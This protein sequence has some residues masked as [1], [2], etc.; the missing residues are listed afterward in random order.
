MELL[1][2]SD[3]RGIH[4]T[5]AW[6][7]AVESNRPGIQ[8][9]NF[10]VAIDP[11][12]AD[13]PS[14][15]VPDLKAW[16]LS[17]PETPRF[18]EFSTANGVKGV[19]K[20]TA[21]VVFE[22]YVRAVLERAGLAGDSERSVHLLMPALADD[23]AHFRYRDV[24]VDAVKAACPRAEISTVS[25]PEMVLEFFRLVK[26]LVRVRRGQNACFLV[27]DSGA[28]TTN[29][30]VILSTRSGDITEASKRRR[31]QN[32][33]AVSFDA[34]RLAG[35][36]VDEELLNRLFPP[37]RG[38]PAGLR[39]EPIALMERAKLAVARTGSPA[40][41]SLPTGDTVRLELPLLHDVAHWLW[42]QLRTKYQEI[43]EVVLTQLKTGAGAK[44]Y[45]AML[46]ERGVSTWRD[47]SKMFDGVFLA[48][49]TGLLPGFVQELRS[50][51]NLTSDTPI[52]SVGGA[53]P[54]AAAI[55]GLAHVLRPRRLSRS[56]DVP[57]E[58]GGDEENVDLKTSLQWNIV[59]DCQDRAGRAS[60]PSKITVVERNQRIA[61]DGGTV[62][63]QLPRSWSRGK[64]SRAR[65]IPS[66]N[67]FAEERYLRKG[68]KFHKL[69]VRRVPAVAR[70]EY[71]S[72]DQR[73]TVRS[74][75]VAGLERLRLEVP[76]LLAVARD[77]RDSIKRR[78]DGVLAVP[79]ASDIVIDLGMSKTLI[80]WAPRACD[81][82]PDA[83]DCA[84]DEVPDE[85]GFAVGT[86]STG[87]SEARENAVHRSIAGE[88][89]GRG[90]RTE[91]TMPVDTTVGSDVSPAVAPRVTPEPSSQSIGPEPETDD[92]PV[93][94]ATDRTISQPQQRLPS[95]VTAT[96]RAPLAA[97]DM[98]GAYDNVRIASPLA[99]EDPVG[100]IRLVAD[101]ARANGLGVDQGELALA[102]LALCTR[103]FVMIA[104]P[105]GSGKS[106]IARL[107]ARVLGC[108]QAGTFADL[109]VQAHWIDDDPLFGEEGG[110]KG[111]FE[112]RDGLRLVLFDEL[113]LTRPEY[114]LARLFGALD[115][116]G[117]I[118]SRRL[119][120]LGVVG[121][122]N[123]DDFS[124]P[125]SPKILDRA[126]LLVTS[127]RQEA[128]D[129]KVWCTWRASSENGRLPDIPPPGV[130]SP[131]LP[132]DPSADWKKRIMVWVEHAHDT[133]SNNHAMRPD[134]VPSR[135]ATDDL[136]R[137]GALHQT[138][139]LHDLIPEAI[140]ADRAILGRFI[141]PLS[142][143]ESE[144]RPLISAW[145]DLCSDL[146]E[147]ARRLDRL[148][149]QADTHG[150]VSFWQ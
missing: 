149:R 104:G 52:H 123:V 10:A 84:E 98:A 111:A 125:P 57:S 101:K 28:S 74:N 29:F 119:A 54:V 50:T 126:M 121:T 67:D 142:G 32:L 41:V 87:D 122:L 136:Y 15:A 134:L 53:Y 43:A 114:Y 6:V 118:A 38:A 95:A 105:P 65:L 20:A 107:L 93:A 129:N 117:R 133:L 141:A 108:A 86:L 69:D 37:L 112:I 91:L 89:D 2:F 62:D 96:S 127:P 83:F 16:L 9:E 113:N 46:E 102:Y 100:R 5:H 132:G 68:L 70:G 81:L 24:L 130:V 1:R 39:N 21:Q 11:P 13:T 97:P 109:P 85:V 128:A 75:D 80:A 14:L 71:D 99:L 90:T 26:N 8:L 76:T 78:S 42:A 49:G 36:A 59:L 22:R 135:R 27:I 146:P 110:L 106:T 25:E 23:D 30:T 51:M 73:L 88:L 79:S 12:S 138:L 116:H 103:P 115:D 139:E 137:F 63:I 7:V 150:F 77:S 33:R 147:S 140:A 18:L 55:G 34:E 17:E 61:I 40:T 148:A 120:P 92:S 64:G 124:R 72:E 82:H 4:R 56:L 45:S 31:T 144:V 94:T 60:T 35:R 48:G 19:R 145:R 44:T 131:V 3:Q 143:P 47:V 66:R 58:A